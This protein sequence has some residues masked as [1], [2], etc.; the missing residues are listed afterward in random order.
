MEM[1]IGGPC[2]NSRPGVC[3]KDRAVGTRGVGG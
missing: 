1:E 3:V 2:R